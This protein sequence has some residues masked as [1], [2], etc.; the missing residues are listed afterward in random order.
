MLDRLLVLPPV[1]C[2][3][4]LLSA[5]IFKSLSLGLQKHISDADSCRLSAPTIEAAHWPFPCELCL[6]PSDKHNIKVFS[7]P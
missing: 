5:S 2:S 7:S 4:P 1:P 6:P 3:D